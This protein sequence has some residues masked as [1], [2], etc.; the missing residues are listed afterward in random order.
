L[1]EEHE[2][3]EQALAFAKLGYWRWDASSDELVLSP[4]AKE[5]FGLDV[6]GRV[7]WKEVH[8]LLVGSDEDKARD[9]LQQAL[10]GALHYEVEYQVLRRVDGATTW[11]CVR[12]R[13]HDDGVTGIVE[14]ITAR[15]NREFTQEYDWQ[16]SLKEKLE[17]EVRARTKE[18]QTTNERL[19]AEAAERER[20]EGGFQLLVENVVD[21]AIFMLNQEGVITNWNM[22]AERIKGYKACEIIGHYFSKFYTEEDRTAGVPQRGLEHARLHGKWE[23]QGWRVRKDGSRFWANVVINAI[24]DR[25]GTLVGF[26][27]VTRDITEGRA[28]QEALKKIQEQLVQSQK[29]EGIGQL[30]GGVAHDFNNLLTII[31]GN[32]DTLSRAV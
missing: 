20:V 9:Q 8:E 27:K 19:M 11:V 25:S 26:A 21:Y 24:R 2:F 7:A 23:A 22:G 14:D 1:T 29:M 17:K 4:R 30:T 32:L 6:S 31:L 10:K 28:A 13:G 3:L 16:S 5:I 12:G 15:K 18:L